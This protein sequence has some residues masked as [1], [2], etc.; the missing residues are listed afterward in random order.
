MFLNWLTRP[1]GNMTYHLIV[2]FA[3]A[4]AWQVAWWQRAAR[5]RGA[6]ARLL[7]GLGVLFALRL[8]LFAL[9]A[10]A[11]Q[12]FLPVHLVLSLA[13]RVV[14]GASLVLLVWLWAFPARGGSAWLLGGGLL[15][16]AALVLSWVGAPALVAHR[17]FNGSW[18]DRGWAILSVTLA[19]S[20]MLVL[21]RRKPP[22][23]VAGLLML[24]ALAVAQVGHFLF[25]P[26]GGDWDGLLRLAD[27]AVSP[28]L[29]ILP[30]RLPEE[31]ARPQPPRSREVAAPRLD[32]AATQALLTLLN[33]SPRAPEACTRLAHTCA[34]L[35]RADLCLVLSPPEHGRVHALCGYDLIRDQSLEP[36]D[37]PEG[38]VPIVTLALNRRRVLHLPAGSTSVD[39][40]A[41]AQ[42]LQLPRAGALLALPLDPG[43]GKPLQ[44]G[45][46]L[47][48]PYAARSWARPVQARGQEL[49]RRFARWLWQAE[50]SP[51]ATAASPSP[52]AAPSN[53]NVVRGETSS[54]VTPP[55]D[56]LFPLEDALDQALSRTAPL[57]Q[58]RQLLLQMDVAP[59]LPATEADGELLSALLTRLLEQAA[60]AAVL[61]SALHLSVQPDQKGARLTLCF[62]SAHPLAEDTWDTIWRT[63]QKIHVGVQKTLQADGRL[64]LQADIASRPFEVAGNP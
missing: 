26:A 6:V 32:D 39:A 64:C 17:F 44:G 48:S 50:K 36:F 30:A 25:P 43:E 29:L 37:L 60:L 38:E 56:N 49:A 1:P 2:L 20:G 3:L 23:A 5:P 57:F 53:S 46:L 31:K 41:L 27:L 62:A 35:L 4:A 21:A 51:P 55:S 33:T 15:I 40:A 45:L 18:I 61:G 12:R 16:V 8:G 34:L 54:D 13:D 10:L 47:L 59:S 19:V 9:G 58:A 52:S 14:L 24:F 22:A 63:A 11:W 7:W 28:F 42:V